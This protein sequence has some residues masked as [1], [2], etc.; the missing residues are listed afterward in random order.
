MAKQNKTN[1]FGGLALQESRIS[2]YAFPPQYILIYS[3]FSEMIG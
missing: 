1:N 3:A 2:Y